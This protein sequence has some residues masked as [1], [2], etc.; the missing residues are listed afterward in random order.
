MLA[1]LRPTIFVK[2]VEE[3]TPA[4][5]R[6][7]RLRSL[8]LDVDCTLTRYRQQETSPEVA[9]WIKQL[10]EAGIGLCLVSTG[11]SQRISEF[12]KRLDLPYVP[13]AMK[14]FPFGIWSALKE[15]NAVPAD[16]AMVGDQVFADIVAGH[17]AGVRTVLVRP[18]HPEEEPWFTQLK[19]GPERWLLEKIEKEK[20]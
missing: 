18:I 16:T 2:R 19:R 17:L 1:I 12:A 9:A 8:L 20:A 5:L 14:P 4:R 3:L 6:G 7:W 15:I 10:R 13:K 11:L